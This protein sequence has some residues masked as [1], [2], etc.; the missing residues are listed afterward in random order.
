MLF[1]SFLFILVIGVVAYAAVAA[2]LVADLPFSPFIF[3]IT[4]T[5]AG[6]AIITL[7]PRLRVLLAPQPPALP[8]T[9]T[10]KARL[11][12]WAFNYLLYFALLPVVV[13]LLILP[14]LQIGY[15]GLFHSG[16]VY[17]I[18]LR[19]LP[20]ENVTLPGFPPNDYWPYHVYLALL[21]RLFNA[22]PPFVS[23]ISNIL[24]LGMSC[25]WVAALWKSL[26]RSDATPPAFYVLF[27]LLGSNLL[28]ILNVKLAGWLD[29]PA[30]LA[31]DVRLDIPLI[32][33]VN[34]NGFS[35]GI[36]LFLAALYF[37]DRLLRND[38]NPH[39]ASLL[40][41]LG[42]AALLFHA[43]TGIFIFGVLIPSL[44]LSRLF[45]RSHPRPSRSDLAWSWPAILKWILP[46]A[47]FLL[48]IGIFLLRAAGAMGAKTA[49]ELF[50][51]TDVSSIFVVAYPVAIFFFLELKRAWK[52]RDTPV[53]FLSFITLLGFLLA[54]FIK[55]PDGN[56]YKFIHL[57]SITLILVAALRLKHCS[58]N[59]SADVSPPDVLT[60]KIRAPI[61]TVLGKGLTAL[62]TLL[63]VYNIAYDTWFFYT[64]Y[65]YRHKV[66]I[67][68]NGQH[69]TLN[70]DD[71]APF[72]W[73]R[74][75]TSPDTV[76]VQ[77]F[78]SKDW[79]YGY[80]SERLPYVVAGHIYNEGLPETAVRQDQVVRLYDTSLP[81]GQR[82][83]IVR[84]IRQSLAR[85]IAV[86]YPADAAF[87]SA[88]AAEFGVP[89]E[90]IG[91]AVV[92]Y[93]LN[94]P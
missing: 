76:I 28:Y 26:T 87:Q 7:A 35:L 13:L 47:L 81:V 57:S 32:R 53:L 5:L 82:T 23:A 49:L 71:F 55:L 14:A 27:P 46:A 39:N 41:F 45:D 61:S 70:R 88:M 33:F 3:P 29:L 50:S 85:P 66:G 79:S 19:G 78:N 10:W 12:T 4:F 20:P 24:L 67:N 63:L 43:T 48:P 75:H 68:Y 90:A 52:E 65:A 11:Q 92:I 94:L 60:S 2:S 69:V 22:P 15:H 18:L 51:W 73:I 59:R 93:V 89:G 1:T 21:S 86:I 74:E 30:Q 58:E 42:A 40:V 36:L 64:T 37:A 44:I 56:E 8:Q 38:F 72:A 54:I 17:Q 6:L 91:N 34:F 25:L 16:Y 62:I 9:Q 84:A 31:P 77:P 80:F 83:E